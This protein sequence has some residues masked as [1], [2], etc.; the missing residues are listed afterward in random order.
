MTVA[1]QAAPTVAFIDEYC[2]CYEDVFPDVR[3]FEHFKYIHLGLLSEIKR[4]T[5][6]AIAKICGEVDA[7]ALHHF[8]AN[9]LWDVQEVRSR[10]LQLLRQ[11]LAGRSFALCIDETGD[12]KKG[13]TTEYAASQYIGNLGKIENGIVSVNAYGVLDQITFPLLFRVFKPD[14]R[15][16]GEDQYKTKPELAVEIIEELQAWG[17]QFDVVLADSLYGESTQFVRELEKRHL[18]Y[19][20]AIRDNHGMWLPPGQRIR[21]TT[22]LPFERTFSNGKS[23]TRFIREVIY[24]QRLSVRFYLLTTDPKTMPTQSTSYVMTNLQGNLRKTLG[25][26]YGLRT[27]I[28]YGFKQAKNELGWADY[29]VTDYTSIERW[30]ELVCCAYL[31]VSLYSPVFHHQ[32]CE[33]L[34]PLPQASAQAP[35]PEA[36]SD[37][38][39]GHV[40]W[41]SRQGW[42]NLLNNL[43][44]IL[45]PY[46][47]Y[48]LISPW[49][50]VFDIPDLHSGFA[51]LVS[52]M[53]DFH[54]S[55]PF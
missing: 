7:Q 25:D 46:V 50:M 11:A 14:K 35:A 22:W 38:F 43:R 37:R 23:Q 55:L 5:L 54:A 32:T 10:R 44:L 15:L 36:A 42:K 34:E 3:S 2:T 17:F 29:R 19:V 48:S 13:K 6:P 27:W 24:G 52:I 26:T 51:A 18:T 28:E 30:W 45:Q 12:K 21:Y 39:S 33:W 16:K 9:G 41:D 1:R 8:V 47:F 4:K 53:N 40:W 49:L 31:L 20:L